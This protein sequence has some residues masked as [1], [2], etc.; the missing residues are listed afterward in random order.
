MDARDA[1]ALLGHG[2]L[3]DG[4]AVIDDRSVRVG[5]R[6]VEIIDNELLINGVPS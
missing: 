1:G 2:D 5:F 3:R 4:G 6:R